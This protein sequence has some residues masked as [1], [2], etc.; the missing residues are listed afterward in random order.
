[1]TKFEARPAIRDSFDEE[2]ASD[3][4]DDEVFIRDGR[5]GYK[6]D[7]ENGVKKP[8][9]PP[10]RRHKYAKF[11]ASASQ[12]P[13]RRCKMFLVPCCYGVAALSVLLGKL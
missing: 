9:M 3:D 2:D 5:N 1:M 8:L 10:R 12:E 7:E 4:V 6:M 13:R 11:A